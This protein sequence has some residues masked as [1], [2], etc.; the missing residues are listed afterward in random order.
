MP[1][2]EVLRRGDSRA[3]AV[4]ADAAPDLD[5]IAYQR[6]LY[7]VPSL[8]PPSAARVYCRLRSASRNCALCPP[9]EATPTG[10]LAHHRLRDVL[11]NL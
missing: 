9:T 6:P 5:L 11:Q 3:A 4:D 8:D 7:Q 2:G 10:T 1:K